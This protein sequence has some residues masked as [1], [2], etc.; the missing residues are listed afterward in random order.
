MARNAER[1]AKAKLCYRE[2]KLSDQGLNWT[3]A[4]IEEPGAAAGAA[5]RHSARQ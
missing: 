4:I 5:D 3:L 1:I 2:E